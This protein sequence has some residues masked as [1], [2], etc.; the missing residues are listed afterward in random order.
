[1]AGSVAF[2]V[3]SD[4]VVRNMQTQFALHL[5]DLDP[6]AFRTA[7]LD[8]VPK[9]L[10]NDP[11]EAQRDVAGKQTRD[12]VMYQLDMNVVLLGNLLAETPGCRHEAKVL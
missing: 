10:L 5:G 6:G 1:M 11:V 4:T 8:D 7:V 3:E 9:R 12:L 2:G